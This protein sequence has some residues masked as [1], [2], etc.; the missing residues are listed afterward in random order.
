MM[1]ISTNLRRITATALRA[2]IKAGAGKRRHR[3]IEEPRLP[4]DFAADP[5]H[6]KT[7]FL[8]FD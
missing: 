3:V 4:P 5:D 6:A 7:I 2:K 1:M 8:R